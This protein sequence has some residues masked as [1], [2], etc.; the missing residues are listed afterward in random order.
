G[1]GRNPE[2]RAVRGPICPAER[3]CRYRCY[4]EPVLVCPRCLRGVIERERCMP[5]SH[6]NDV[7]HW[8]DRAAEMRA[9]SDVMTETEAVAI[10][11]RLADDYDKL[12]D[13]ALI[14][15]DGGAPAN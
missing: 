9:L 5:S 14:R 10:M 3:C 13:R 6:V 2:R 4:L 1:R 11:L 7:K 12:A 15:L 8:R